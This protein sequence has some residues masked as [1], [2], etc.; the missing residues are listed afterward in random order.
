MG[1]KPFSV[2]TDVRAGLTELA[3]FP[4]CVDEHGLQYCC[5]E[6]TDDTNHAVQ[7]K[8][9]LENKNYPEHKY[10]WDLASCL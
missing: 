1:A 2:K 6:A 3:W 9:C 5:N 8:Q 10:P 7:C 4:K